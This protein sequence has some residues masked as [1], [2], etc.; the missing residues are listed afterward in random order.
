LLFSFFCEEPLDSILTNSSVHGT[1]LNES[2]LIETKNGINS[3]PDSYDVIL[4]SNYEL[5]LRNINPIDQGDFDRENL[6]SQ[7]TNNSSE[8][9]M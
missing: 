8:I 6:I 3:S 4:T 7:G 1:R 9:C 5:K 2:S